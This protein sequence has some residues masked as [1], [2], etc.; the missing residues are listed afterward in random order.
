MAEGLVQLLKAGYNP[1]WT[2]ALQ[3][4]TGVKIRRWQAEN[5]RYSHQRTPTHADQAPEPRE[6]SVG[7]FR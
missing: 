2:L 7:E 6:V 5:L 1:S 4:W 3:E